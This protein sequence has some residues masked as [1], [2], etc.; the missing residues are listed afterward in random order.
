MAVEIGLV[1]R[2]VGFVMDEGVAEMLLLWAAMDISLTGCGR[3]EL[4]KCSP[5]E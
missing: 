2:G 4:N 1:W 3:H 5:N